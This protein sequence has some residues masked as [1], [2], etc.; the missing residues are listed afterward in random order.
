MIGA[1][2][3]VVDGGGLQFLS[4]FLGDAPVVD[5]P[6]HVVGAGA[7][8][9]APPGVG[10]GFIGVEVAESVNESGFDEFGESSPFLIGET[11]TFVVCLRAGEVDLFVRD[12]EIA[13]GKDRFS[14]GFERLEVLTEGDVPFHAVGKAEEFVLGVRGVNGDEK[15]VGIFQGDDTAFFVAFGTAMAADA[16][17]DVEGFGFGEDGGA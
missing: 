7:S 16:E 4:E 17:A 1:R 14:F 3:I 10:V 6:S 13:A 11:G 12:I 15:V 2:D 5:S 9:I 8:P